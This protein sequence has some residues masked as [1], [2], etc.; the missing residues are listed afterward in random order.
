MLGIAIHFALSSGAVHMN[1]CK[2]EKKNAD[3]PRQAM[4]GKTF[5]NTTITKK[6]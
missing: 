6:K 1:I 5:Y 3:N 2:I 4:Q